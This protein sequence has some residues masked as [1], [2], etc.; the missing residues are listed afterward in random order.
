MIRK[1]IVLLMV[2]LTFI[3]TVSLAE[4][5]MPTAKV[6]VGIWAL[7]DEDELTYPDKNNGLG[8]GDC[9]SLDG[10]YAIIEPP[11]RERYKVE[12]I[13]YAGET[14]NKKF[15]N[16]VI[17]LS[18]GDVIEGYIYYSPNEYWMMRANGSL[19]KR[20]PLND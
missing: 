9:F 5:A 16:F 14:K 3:F 4:A 12:S 2:L 10:V 18:G 1:Y 6:F 15:Y 13:K 20:C 8:N 7:A 17:R 11:D 19:W